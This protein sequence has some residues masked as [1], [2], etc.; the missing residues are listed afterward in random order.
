M[1]EL[2]E[3]P[4]NDPGE[5]C[6]PRYLGTT[7]T[8]TASES[9]DWHSHGFGELICATSGSMYVGTSD[10]VLLLSPAMVLWMP[11]DVQHWMRYGPNN[12]LRYVDVHR[13]EA[14]MIGEKCRIIAVTPLLSA[15]MAET[16]PQKGTHRAE[17]H[18]AALHDLL[19]QE[20]IAA[21]DVPLSLTLPRDQRIRRFAESA[22]EDPGLIES[23]EDWLADAAASRKTVERLFVSETGMP[24]SQWL[25]QARLFHAISRLSAGEKVST[26][27]F[28]MGYA[29]SSAFSYMFRRSLGRSPSDFCA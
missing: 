8:S 17:G 5:A 28:D 21:P 16:V 26:V 20:L 2:K 12:E 13:D 14:R 15:L 27:A 29:S 25:R 11:P 7:V 3:Y 18:K 22:L 1:T 4:Q 23:V 6:M 10:R 9:Y 19:R 24:P